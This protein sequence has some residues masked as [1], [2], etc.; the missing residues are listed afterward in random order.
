M[1]LAIGGAGGRMG[2]A[3]GRFALLEKDLKVVV[4]IEHPSSK[5]VGSDFGR[6]AGQTD[7]GVRF[8][9]ALDRK[10]DALIDFSL[11]SASMER[12]AECVRHTTPMVIGTTG[13]SP[14]QREDIRKASQTIPIL[15]ST[16]MSVG[17]NLLF[18]IVGEVARTL[19]PSYD[20]EIVETHHRLKM[21]AP[22][23]T[24]MT[25]AERI[26]E[27]A[28][29]RIPQDLRHGREGIVGERPRGEIGMH[30][31]RGGDVIGEH[32][33]LYAGDGE[34]IE[35]VHRAGS[36]DI[37]A[38]GALRAARFIAQAKPGLYS[39]VDALGA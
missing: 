18:R 34:T 29:R 39:M 9:T 30:A 11:P 19:G 32:R 10:V 8:V 26:A 1:D 31:V 3:I 14:D 22:S 21:D 2:T 24:A 28:G 4:A 12:V 16:N 36:R 17:V 13:F 25:L 23:G 27:A 33:V 6:H 35:I 15:M 38:R 7:S 37:Y 5:L 20:V